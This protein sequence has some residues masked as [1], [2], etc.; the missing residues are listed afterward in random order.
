MNSVSPSIH[1]VC[2]SSIIIITYTIYLVYPQS[3][4]R[5]V[6][7]LRNDRDCCSVQMQSG[8]KSSNFFKGNYRSDLNTL[9]RSYCVDVDV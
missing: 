5:C 3:M 1:I 9:N 2:H 8:K 7:F 6:L 4:R